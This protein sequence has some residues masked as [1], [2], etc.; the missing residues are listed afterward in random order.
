MAKLDP[1]YERLRNKIV[2][3]KR[4]PGWQKRLTI[5][6]AVIAVLSAGV[7]SIRDASQIIAGRPY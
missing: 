5:A 1:E 2:S 7:L 6:A 4:K 3:A